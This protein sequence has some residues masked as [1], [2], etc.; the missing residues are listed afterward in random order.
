MSYN[1]STMRENTIAE[2]IDARG[3]SCPQPV[4]ITKKKMDE[5][6][7][8]IIEI[9]VDTA[10]SRDNIERMAQNQGWRVAIRES[11]DSYI[12]TISKEQ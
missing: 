3:L 4:V 8:G 9:T 2:Q 5:L 12:L 7:S 10:T 6:G 1:I 11:G